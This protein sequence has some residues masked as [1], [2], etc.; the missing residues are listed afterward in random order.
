MVRLSP[1][2]VAGFAG[3]VTCGSV[4][5]EPV[6]NAKIMARRAVEVGAAIALWQAQ[7][8]PVAFATFT[9]RHRK[10]QPLASLWDA[11]S[12]AWQRA[13]GGKSWYRDKALHRVAG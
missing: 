5:S 12:G 8:H 2:G 9:M 3:V 10:G 11:L 1:A 4:W 6:C 7:G 13:V